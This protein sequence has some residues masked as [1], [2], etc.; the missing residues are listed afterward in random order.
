MTQMKTLLSLSLIVILLAQSCP[1]SAHE[2][3]STS[4]TETLSQ[5]VQQSLDHRQ[6]CCFYTRKHLQIQIKKR[7]RLVPRAGVARARPKSSAIRTQTSSIQLCSL[8]VY[9][10]FFG[11]FL[12]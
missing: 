4:L 5:P 9:F 11:F 12:L 2:G 8:F 10:V 1:S 6:P 3:V 7:A